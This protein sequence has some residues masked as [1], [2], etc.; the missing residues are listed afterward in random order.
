MAPWPA[1]FDRVR[2]WY[3]PHLEHLMPMRG[4]RRRSLDQMQRI[5]ATYAS[6]GISDRPDPRSAAATSDQAGQ[7][8]RDE[9]YLSSRPSTLPTGRNE[10]VYVSE[11]L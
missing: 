9:D 5:A 2:Q 3:Q 4:P 11:R 8:L 10:A 6:R 7:L 1:E